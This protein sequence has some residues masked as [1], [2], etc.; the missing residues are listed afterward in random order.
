MYFDDRLRSF[1]SVDNGQLVTVVSVIVVGVAGEETMTSPLFLSAAFR[2]FGG[3]KKCCNGSS[4]CLIL[5]FDDDD[6][7]CSRTGMLGFFFS[8][9]FQDL[10]VLLLVVLLA[11]AGDRGGNIIEAGDWDRARV[12]ILCNTLAFFF[13]FGDLAA[14]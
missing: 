5:P 10:S 11:V 12:R 4:C 8:L 1:L 3:D 6:F 2:C 9:G 13:C 14:S 7:V